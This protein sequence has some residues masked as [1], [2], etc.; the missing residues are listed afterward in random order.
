MRFS[1]AGQGVCPACHSSNI[2]RSRRQEGERFTRLF[3]RAYRCDQCKTR[4][5]RFNLLQ[6]NS[7]LIW[8]GWVLLFVVFVV[9]LWFA[10]KT[11]SQPPRLDLGGS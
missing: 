3:L 10:M 7:V 8:V 11:L 9:F 5:W 4:F 1:F 2:H 6:M